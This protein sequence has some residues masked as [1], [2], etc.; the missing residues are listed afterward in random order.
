[1]EHVSINRSQQCGA[2]SLSSGPAAVAL[3][4]RLNVDP[5]G[6]AEEEAVMRQNVPSTSVP[7]CQL[8]RPPPNISLHVAVLLTTALEVSGKSQ[9][10]VWS[11]VADLI[12]SVK[13]II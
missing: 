11:V 5:G 9:V 1:V 12:F 4:R 8:P 6:T 13:F 2:A 3:S 10:P 7:H